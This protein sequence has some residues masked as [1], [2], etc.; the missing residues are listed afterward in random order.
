MKIYGIITTIF[1]LSI[2][3]VSC[4]FDDNGTNPPVVT[5]PTIPN[6]PIPADGSS[7]QDNYLELSW[8]C[9]DASSY[10]VYFDT[11]NPPL[12][13]EKSNISENRVVV[14]AA[15]RGVK[16]YWQVSARLTN[17][18]VSN[19]PVWRFTTRSTGT[20]QPGFVMTEYSLTT[21]PPSNVEVLF[22]VEDLMGKGVDYL[23]VNDFEL[24]EDG[25]KISPTESNLQINQ[26]QVDPFILRTVLMLDNSASL[27]DDPLHPN[28]LDILKTAAKSFVNNM[29]AQQ[30]VSL[31]KFSSSPEKLTGFTND[32]AILEAAI[33]SIDKGFA[34][35]DL[36][37]AVIEG[38]NQWEDSISPDSVIHGDLALFTDGSDTQGRHTLEEALDAI[39]TKSVYTVG[40]G[41]E[42]DPEIL[43]LLGTSGTFT[44]NEISL[45]NQV[46]LQIQDEIEATANSFYWMEYVS[47]KRGNSDH[48]LELIIK[49]NLFPSSVKGEFSSI[50][51]YDPN[52]GVY[53]NTSFANPDGTNE[54]ILIIG[55]PPIEITAVTYGGTA[56]PVY[57][58][59]HSP[60]LMI[61]YLD[62]PINS[63]VKILTTPAATVRDE[64]IAVTDMVNGFQSNILIH[65]NN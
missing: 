64:W 30:V 26:R 4:V 50:G 65:V 12:H 18:S 54:Y 39:G 63:I 32:K 10:I 24:Y 17:G 46:F 62:P 43:R 59:A 6:T 49:D 2:L 19:G 47:P 7:N 45:L 55:G 38:V 16:H 9:A 11:Q 14:Y 28:N 56:A 41:S 27:T 35:T 21:S 23:T 8:L 48:I 36:Y 20:A 29:D 31:Y 1:L 52:P 13:I 15:G 33:N 44:I 3:S 61:A 25:E 5:D 51:F 22:Q 53:F 57:F 37:G 34:T 58:W 40:L 60:S 42:I